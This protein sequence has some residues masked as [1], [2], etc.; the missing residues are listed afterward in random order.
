VSPVWISRY[1]GSGALHTCPYSSGSTRSHD[2]VVCLKESDSVAK[3]DYAALGCSDV[4]CA[5]HVVL[6]SGRQCIDGLIHYIP[7]VSYYRTCDFT[8]FSFPQN[9]HATPSVRLIHGRV[10]QTPS[11]PNKFSPGVYKGWI[12]GGEK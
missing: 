8:L 1:R 7:S 9:G 12:R 2:G 11:V 4:V 10:T 6:R 3:W 5:Q